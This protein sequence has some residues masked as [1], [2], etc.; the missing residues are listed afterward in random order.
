VGPIADNTSQTGTDTIATDDVTTLNGGASSGVKVQRTKTTFGD[1]GTSRDVSATFPLPAGNT[2]QASG[3]LSATD[4][5]VAAPVGDGTIITGASTAGSVVS[6]SIPSGMSSWTML[7]K[8]YVSGTIYSE[9]S[10]NSTN[11]TDGDWVE[12]KGRRTGTAPGTET[13]TYA[14]TASGYYR[15]NDGGFIYLRARLIG[16]TGATVQLTASSG[17]GAVFLN[18]SLPGGTSTIGAIKKAPATT[19]TISSVTSAAASTLL[20]ASNTNRLGA[21]VYNDSTATLYLAL[22]SSASTTA[23]T[24]QVTAGGYFEL[25]NDGCGYTGAI[26]GIWSAANGFARVT[27]LT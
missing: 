17:T 18:S 13:I 19:G 21:T 23:Y 6:L 26:Y 25:P 10:T 24:V 1:D 20:L 22:A 15:G 12:V 16:G 7:L 4:A 3:T 11:G 9:A 2:V 8:G 27:E 14:Y 5:V